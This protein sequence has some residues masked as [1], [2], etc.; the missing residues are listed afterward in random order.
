[1]L[2]ALGMVTCLG[3]GLALGAAHN[4]WP[5]AAMWRGPIVSILLSALAS[6]VAA[7]LTSWLVLPS[8][9]SDAVGGASI[10]ESLKGLGWV[11][12]AV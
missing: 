2:W 1:M 10:W 7:I 5:I 3:Y 8:L 9:A 11:E 4:V 6:A 12:L